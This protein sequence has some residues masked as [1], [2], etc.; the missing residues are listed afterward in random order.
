MQLDKDRPFKG[1]LLQNH[2]QQDISNFDQHNLLE[3]MLVSDL[4]FMGVLMV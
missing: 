4:N 2:L 3:M 1:C